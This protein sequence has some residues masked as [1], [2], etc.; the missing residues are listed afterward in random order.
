MTLEEKLYTE[1]FDQKP[2]LSSEVLDMSAI[3]S[4]YFMLDINGCGDKQHDFG[5]KMYS[6]DIGLGP[7]SLACWS[8]TNTNLRNGSHFAGTFSRDTK[9]VLHSMNCV[10]K[11]LPKGVDPRKALIGMAG[12]KYISRNTHLGPSA[13][14]ANFE[15]KM[16][17]L[18]GMCD[19]CREAS[20]TLDSKIRV[21]NTQRDKTL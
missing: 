2:N 1:V 7:I 4:I 21:L 16:P 11:D 15:M 20:E 9:T 18:F 19:F 8:E 10:L 17:E 3:N 5:W 12:Y 13:I 6:D 14:K